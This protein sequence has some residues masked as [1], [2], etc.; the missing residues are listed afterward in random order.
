M[1]EALHLTPQEIDTQAKRSKFTATIV[2]CGHKGILYANMFAD[3]GFTVVCTDV[4]ASVVKKVAKGKIASTM[5]E[6]E[7]KL[8]SHINQENINVTGELKRAISQSDIVVVTLTAKTDE[9]KKNNYTELVNTC[10]QVGTVLHGGTLVVYGGIAGVGFIEGTFKELLE[11][12]SGLKAGKDFGLAYSPLIATNAL[13]KDLVLTVAASDE[14]SLNAASVVLK[15]LTGNITEIIGLKTAEIAALF[16]IAKQ[17][18]FLALTN[19]FAVFCENTNTDYFKVLDAL[20][21]NIPCFRPTIDGAENCDG[22]YLLLEDAENLNIKL[23]LS[24]LARQ[25]NEEMVKHAVNLTQ[26]ALRSCGTTLRRG[27]V[28][29]LGSSSAR[30]CFVKLIEQ[31]GAK[32]TV[33]DPSAKKDTQEPD[34]IK[35]SL[36]ETVEGADCIIIIGGQDQFS[37][38]NL[39]KLKSIMKSPSVVDLTGKFN[40][41]QVEIEGFLYFGL[42]K[43]NDKK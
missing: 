40:A 20:N 38:L 8:K 5:P 29:V 7:A 35:N 3:A 37:R 14:F 42:G 27:R 1:S 4:D 12:T 34:N 26:E 10:K 13:P 11:N 43:G 9:Q 36:N 2:G 6:A 31:K 15:T 18:A 16:T 30:D 39:K 23:R 25:I 33:Y 22:A 17:D 32:V 24:A 21:L 19:E 41:R 28:A